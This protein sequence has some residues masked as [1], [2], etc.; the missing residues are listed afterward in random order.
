MLKYYIKFI[1]NA[2]GIII[3]EFS[4]VL[5]CAISGVHIFEIKYFQFKSTA[6]YVKHAEPRN[7]IQAFFIVLGPLFLGSTISFGLFYYILYNP[8]INL[9][10]AIALWFAITI[11][12]HSFPSDGDGKTLLYIT[13]KQILH[14]KNPF[15]L[16]LYPFVLLIKIINFLKKFYLDFLY[17]AFLFGLAWYIIYLIK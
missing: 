8:Q 2:P 9:L 16:F 11:G 7:I 10:N 3:H 13:N 6:G 14:K 1:I 4:H 5:F 12:T 15:A 17:T